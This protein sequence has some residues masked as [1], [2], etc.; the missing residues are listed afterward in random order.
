MKDADLSRFI[1][2][3]IKGFH[4]NDNKKGDNGSP[5]RTPLLTANS[6]VGAPF[7]RTDVREELRHPNIHFLHVSGKPNCSK[8]A[9]RKL[10]FRESNALL[11]STLNK[12]AS[13]LDFL[14]QETASLMISGPSSIFLLPMKAVCVSPTIDPITALSR[15]ARTLEIT[16]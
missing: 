3:S 11:K 8:V 4:S 10:Q 6:F 2:N 13:R 5:C 12:S 16:L 9:D 1:H 7:T 15:L 14:S